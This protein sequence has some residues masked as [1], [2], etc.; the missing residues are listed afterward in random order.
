MVVA[1]LRR[2]AEAAA[3]RLRGVP[4]GEVRLVVP[5]GWGP[6]GRT[7]IRE[8]ARR[9]GLGQPSLVD[10]PSAAAT[11]LVASGRHLMVGS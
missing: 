7:A 11:H 8:A 1:T 6:L 4:L 9:A 2:V 5:A 3:A 10:A